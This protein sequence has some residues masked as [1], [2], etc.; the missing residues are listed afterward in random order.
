MIAILPAWV[1]PA[2]V[3]ALVALLLGVAWKGRP[4]R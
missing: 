3:V 1:V 2:A 4:R